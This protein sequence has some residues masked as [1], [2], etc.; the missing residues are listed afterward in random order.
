MVNTY[1][2][3]CDVFPGKITA[4]QKQKTKIKHGSEFISQLQAREIITFKRNGSKLL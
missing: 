2:H 4:V 3:Y 1:A